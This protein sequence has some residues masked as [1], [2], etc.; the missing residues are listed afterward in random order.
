M[1]TLTL[2]LTTLGALLL[3]PTG[4]FAHDKHKDDCNDALAQLYADRLAHGYT[5]DGQ[6][7]RGYENCAPRYYRNDRDCDPRYRD[8]RRDDR[9]SGFWLRSR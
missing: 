8:D 6:P 4:A 2:A 7:A 5:V 3:V 1:K 9:R